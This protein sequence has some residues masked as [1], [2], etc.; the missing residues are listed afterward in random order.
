MH[1][2]LILAS[3]LL[4][5]AGGDIVLALLPGVADWRPRRHLQM[6]V[7]TAPSVTL[8]VGLLRLYHFDH[9]ICFLGAPAW[10][11][12]LSTVLPLAMGTV[13][14]G[15]AGLGLLRTGLLCWAIRRRTVTA[16][17]ELRAL[18]DHIALRLGISRPRLRI[19]A[20]TR[21]LALTTG[22]RRP[23]LVLSTWMLRHLDGRELESVLAHELGHTAR[24]DYPVIWLATILRDAFFYLPTS[25]AAYRLLHTDK[26]LACDDLAVAAT[27]RR[28][29]L[30]SALAKAWQHAVGEPVLGAIPGFA[31]PGGG[32]EMRIA[33]ILRGARHAEAMAVPAASRARSAD[34][35]ASAL[36][37]LVTVQV[38]AMAVMLL[39]PTACGPSSPVWKVL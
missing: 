12:L 9:R 22:V 34:L 29:A 36:V 8:G 16:G 21:P 35:G 6:L 17:P 27:G 26:E 15:A 24:R 37:D 33:R 39:M 3:L 32:I 13:A 18:A 19:R 2:L 4:V 20:S 10:D 14:L 25:R 30:A 31:H 11:R 38:A 5:V 28:L 23:T 7:L 1:T